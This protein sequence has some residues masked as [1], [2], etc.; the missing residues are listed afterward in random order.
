MCS[1]G[2][3]VLSC[4]GWRVEGVAFVD[5]NTSERCGGGAV[6]SLWRVRGSSACLVSVCVVICVLCQAGC[7][8]WSSRSGGVAE[9]VSPE[10]SVAHIFYA[11]YD[12]PEHRVASGTGFLVGDQGLMVTAAHVVVEDKLIDVRFSG[13]D[14]EQGEH[15]P[16]R[17]ITLDEERDV[18]LLKIDPGSLPPGVVVGSLASERP[19]I[20]DEVSIY[21]FPES[22]IVGLEMRRSTGWISAERQNPLNRE[23]TETRMLELE[24]KIEPGNSGSPVFNEAFEIVGVV[25]SRWETT[26]SYALAAPAAVVRDLLENEYPL[27]LDAALLELES[28]PDSFVGEIITAQALASTMRGHFPAGSEGA[29]RVEEVASGMD[30]AMTSAEQGLAALKRREIARAWRH[31]QLMRHKTLVYRQDVAVL[32]AAQRAIQAGQE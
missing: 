31:L 10:S 5:M 11:D 7:A 18:A 32:K 25:S 21:G 8:T 17:V 29:A 15:V 28:M 24:A 26:D 6:S 2:A 9:G 4:E 20:G 27:D 14:G 19:K 30:E 1:L 13:F 3:V 23:D 12:S 16:A 22:N